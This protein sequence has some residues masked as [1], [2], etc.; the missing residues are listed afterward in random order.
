MYIFLLL[1]LL[2][3]LL[4]LLLLKTTHLEPV[5]Q[6]NDGLIL[7]VAKHSLLLS[8]ISLLLLTWKVLSSSFSTLFFSFR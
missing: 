1:L 8:F 5:S 6:D 3:L 4:F 7:K 2:F